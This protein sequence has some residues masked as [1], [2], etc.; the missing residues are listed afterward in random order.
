MRSRDEIG[1]GEVGRGGGVVGGVLR[2][3]GLCWRLDQTGPDWIG[4]N[5]MSA[6]H[7]GELQQSLC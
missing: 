2:G 7:D 6:E 1:G 3:F 5:V 4:C